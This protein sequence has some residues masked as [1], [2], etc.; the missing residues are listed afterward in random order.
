MPVDYQEI[1]RDIERAVSAAVDAPAALELVV[2]ELH[3]KIPH[4]DWTGI[5][6]LE[7]ESLTLESFRGAP[8][9]HTKIPL[10]QG[11]CG[12]A[13]AARETIVVP[14]VHDD[15]RYLACSVQTKSELVVPIMD[16]DTCLGE[17]DIDSH[18]PAAFSSED[19]KLLEDLAV[20][21]ARILN[22]HS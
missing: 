17:I 12:A 8:S 22:R 14:D 3:E 18:T 15:E 9:P 21:L 10:G 20:L 7:G 2:T 4:F 11:I 19:Q 1:R 5:Y 16:G 6:L 13:A